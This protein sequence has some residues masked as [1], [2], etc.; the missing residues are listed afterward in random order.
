MEDAKGS[1]AVPPVNVSITDTCPDIGPGGAAFSQSERVS[2]VVGHQWALHGALS[3]RGSSGPAGL[4]LAGAARG[5]AGCIQGA[6]KAG[7]RCMRGPAGAT[8]APFFFFF[9]FFFF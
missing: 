3:A 8:E 4:R 5:G 7:L 9:F 2:S 6:S 1:A